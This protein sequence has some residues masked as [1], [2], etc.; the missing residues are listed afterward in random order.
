MYRLYVWFLG[1]NEDR[2]TGPWWQI[3][4]PSVIACQLFLADCAIF[5]QAYTIVPE[6]HLDPKELFIKPPKGAHIVYPNKPTGK[7]DVV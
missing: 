1:I 6:A 2:P 3:S 4:L 5:L 7:W